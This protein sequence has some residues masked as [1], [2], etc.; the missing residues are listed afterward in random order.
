MTESTAYER[1]FKFFAAHFNNG[2]VYDLLHKTLAKKDTLLVECRSDILNIMY[3]THGHNYTVDVVIE[4]GTTNEYLVADED[5]TDIVMVFEN[6]NMSVSE[7]FLLRRLRA[8][9]ENMAAYY[10]K[11]ISKLCK[12]KCVSRVTV[13][14]CEDY[15]RC[16]THQKEVT[17]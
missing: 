13:K 2:P 16:A 6:I 11:E 8:T 3:Q 1:Q 15:D 4:G 9:T 14:V 10:V 7:H 5:I 17:S 12:D